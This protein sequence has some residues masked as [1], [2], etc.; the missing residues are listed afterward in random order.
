MR[1]INQIIVHCSDTYP[2]MDI[3]ADEIRHWHVVDNGWSDI[4]YHYVI[5]RS[6][7]IEHGRPIEVA[8]SHAAGHNAASIGV[9][10]VG[11][12]ARGDKQPCNF[13]A[14]QW[15][16]LA[17]LIDTLKRDHQDINSVLGHNNVSS[18]TCPTFDV[19]A[20]MGE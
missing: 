11:G 13:T 14:R 15:A 8:G 10:L 17:I 2:D 4:G 7:E 16:T 12:K 20:W 3:G 9:C 6:G 5:R 19:A 18:K 1:S